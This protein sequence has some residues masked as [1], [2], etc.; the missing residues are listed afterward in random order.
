MQHKLGIH[1]ATLQL[2]YS[3]TPT[4]LRDPAQNTE[5]VSICSYKI[6][7]DFSASQVEKLCI[8]YMREMR[9][10]HNILVGKT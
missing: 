7:T 10:A 2:D 5:T 4:F 9:N 8:F 3:V 6:N 1:L